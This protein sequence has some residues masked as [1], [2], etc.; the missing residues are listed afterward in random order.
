[1]KVNFTNKLTVFVVFYRKMSVA[2]GTFTEIAGPSCLT[3][4][5]PFSIMST[6]E[7]SCSNMM[8]SSEAATASSNS[9][10]ATTD[11]TTMDE[12]T[13]PLLKD[14]AYMREFGTLLFDLFPDLY[15]S[16]NSLGIFCIS[17]FIYYFLI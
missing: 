4:D 8:E 2:E 11:V 9:C 16:I 12:T 1:V 7:E 3:S 13:D 6:I 17:S 15:D 5:L 10:L 14:V